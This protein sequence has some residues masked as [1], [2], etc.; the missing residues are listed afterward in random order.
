MG[1]GRSGS[2]AR[3]W[4]IARSSRSRESPCSIPGI[5]EPSGHGLER[6][7]PGRVGAE[8]A[9]QSAGPP[10]LRPIE[11]D[12]AIAERDERV[13]SDDEMVEQVDVEQSAG[14][15]RLGRQVEVVR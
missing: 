12:A 4:R 6:V 8:F 9:R 10:T 7:E 13:V 11:G 1:V 5:F 14:G 3:R 15:Q 2:A